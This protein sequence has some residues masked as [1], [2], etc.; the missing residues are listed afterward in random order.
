MSLMSPISRH[1]RAELSD[2]RALIA[3]LPER[4]RL[5][6]VMRFWQQADESEIAEA[7]GGVTTRAVRYTLRRAYN[8]LRAWYG[9]ET[10]NEPNLVSDA[11][12]NAD[13]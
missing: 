7:L 5:A 1:L 9:D 10:T 13:G 11:E 8:R 2:L 6:V 12:E 3:R 4:E